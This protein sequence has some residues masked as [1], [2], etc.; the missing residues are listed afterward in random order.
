[1]SVAERIAPPTHRLPRP[2][3]PAEQAARSQRN[4]Y[5]LEL[6]N[7]V[8]VEA[9]TAEAL[10]AKRRRAPRRA[11]E[12]RDQIPTRVTVTEGKH[13]KVNFAFGYGSEEKARAEIDW[14]HVN[15]FGGAR[16]A[17]VLARY[18]GLDRGVKL[19]F[20]QPYLF[21]PRYSFGLSGQSWF[22]D[23][24]AFKLTT[25]GGRA[26]ITREFRR[27]RS[28]IVGTPAA[29]SLAL[30]YVNEWEEYEIS[31][32]AL[33]DPT[34]RDELIALGLDPR[35]GRGPKCFAD[36]PAGQ[37]SSV[38]LDAGRNTTDSLLDA[39]RLRGDYPLRVGGIV[40]RRRL[41]LPR[42]V[43]RGPLLPVDRLARRGRSAR[44]RRSI[45]P[46]RR[47]VQ[48]KR[49]G[50]PSTNRFPS[51]SATSWEG[52]IPFAAGAGTKSPRSARPGWRLAD[53]A[54]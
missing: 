3:V 47:A 33:N 24:P 15:F 49:V 46:T 35:C 51:S 19:N 18:S 2:A 44:P 7:F 32:D 28:P 10:P 50:R 22:S 11:A 26:T 21:H 41:G 6:F 52:P 23:E 31:N 8:N 34:F 25:I 16:T 45:D 38:F 42:G 4:L 9:L 37:L 5:S 54:S 29:M 20:K 27:A 12:R 17:G 36:S 14:R 1:M 48:P 30:T 39:A 13:R 40:A 43:A 53:R